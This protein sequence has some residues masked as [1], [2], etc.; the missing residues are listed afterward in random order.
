MESRR[1]RIASASQRYL[2]CNPFHGIGMGD[3]GQSHIAS[4]SQTHLP[5]SSQGKFMKGV[6]GDRMAINPVRSPI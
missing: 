5:I 3:K 1:S 2:E 4:A 6:K